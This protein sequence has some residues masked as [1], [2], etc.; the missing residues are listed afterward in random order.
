MFKQ[1]ILDKENKSHIKRLCLEDK[2]KN[3]STKYKN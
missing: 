1:I 3:R 2:P